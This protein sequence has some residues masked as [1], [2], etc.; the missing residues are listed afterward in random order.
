MKLENPEELEQ[1]ITT[2]DDLLMQAHT[3]QRNFCHDYETEKV[4]P[5]FGESA[6]IEAQMAT[7][8]AHYNTIVSTLVE[9][10]GENHHYVFH[11]VNP[12]ATSMHRIDLPDLAARF[13]AR[14]ATHLRA[15]D[16]VI[17]RLEDRQNLMVRKQIAEQEHD[18]DIV[19]RVTYSSHRRQIKVNGILIANPDFSSENELFFDYVYSNPG[20]PI[21]IAE[22]VS[23]VNVGEEL[24]KR[25]SDIVRDLGFTGALK[26]VFFPGVTKQHVMFVNPITKK[27]FY[28][29]DLPAI[30]FNKVGRQSEPQGDTASPSD[31]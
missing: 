9:W 25:P 19:Y 8:K 15:L 7:L 27:Y 23:K 26:E 21:P 5:S 10:M 6:Y 14:Y 20:R 18:G 12:E 22:F 16:E 11:F 4:R 31:A 30:D 2:L 13:I 24:K 28:E 1:L 17:L 3:L 29:H